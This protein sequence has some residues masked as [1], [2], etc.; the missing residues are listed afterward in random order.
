MQN[1]DSLRDDVLG[2]LLYFDNLPP[3]KWR[4][5]DTLRLHKWIKDKL[6][7]YIEGLDRKLKGQQ[8]FGVTEEKKNDD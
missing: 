1:E 2:E 3:S 7:P 8:Q 4:G 6:V 5:W